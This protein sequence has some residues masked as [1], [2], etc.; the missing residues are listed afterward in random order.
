[1]ERKRGSANGESQLNEKVAGYP[2]SRNG[3][4]A[5]DLPQRS[6]PLP[7]MHDVLDTTIIGWQDSIPIYLHHLKSYYRKALKRGHDVLRNDVL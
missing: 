1:V 5:Q 3:R 6:E 4:P 2:T 7:P